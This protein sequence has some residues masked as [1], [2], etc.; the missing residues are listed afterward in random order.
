VHNALA[1]VH[2]A[3]EANGPIPRPVDYSWPWGEALAVLDEAAPDARV[4]NLETGITRSDDFAPGKGVHYRMNPE[5]L[6]C[7]T[8]AE[9]DV[10][11]LA[12]NHALDFG[13]RGLKETLAALA[14]AGLRT[15]GA[16]RNA[17]EARRP[18]IVPTASGSRV[19]VFSFGTPSSGIPRSW[20]ARKD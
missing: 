13:T 5:N 20:A 17:E 18:A 19:L 7:L 1:Y 6:P 11:V 9:P 15:A 2:L 14:A 12:N 3:E 4:V 8:A 16:G 10:C